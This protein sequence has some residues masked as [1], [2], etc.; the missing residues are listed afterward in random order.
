MTPKF[1]NGKVCCGEVQL[2]Y[3][4]TLDYSDQVKE[5]SDLGILIPRDLSTKYTT[6]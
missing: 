1:Q 6:W 3:I 2:E 4:Y 5:Q